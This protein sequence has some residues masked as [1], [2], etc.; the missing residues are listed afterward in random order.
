MNTDNIH[1]E[2]VFLGCLFKIQTLHY[3]SV[4]LNLPRV[5]CEMIIRLG[6][7]KYDQKAL[8]FGKESY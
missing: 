3:G 7:R 2:S 4:S 5:A 8:M 6:K 1:I